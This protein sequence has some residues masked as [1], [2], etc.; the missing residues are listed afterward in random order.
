M[1]EK[2]SRRYFLNLSSLVV[3]ATIVEQVNT[4]L[5]AQLQGWKIGNKTNKLPLG[6][7]YLLGDDPKNTGILPPGTNKHLLA[8]GVRQPSRY[9]TKAFEVSSA[10]QKQVLGFENHIVV[11][12]NDRRMAA[13][14]NKNLLVIG[15]PV[16]TDNT[17]ALCGYLDVQSINDPNKTIPIIDPKSPLPFYFYIGNENGYGYWG[18]EYRS[19]RRWHENGKEDVFPLYGIYDKEKKIYL[20]QPQIGKKSLADML[21]IIRV[22]N[23]KNN[24]RTITIIG[25]LHGYSL[26]SFFLALESNMEIFSKSINPNGF[27]YFQALLPYSLDNNGVASFN[28]NGKGEWKTKI[29]EIEPKKFL[30][31][32]NSVKN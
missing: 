2:K 7:E 6:L 11:D 30:S 23:P 18:D 26:E 9:V 17:K 10:I 21:M 28:I 27:K 25:G 32:Q 19:I 13:N 29:K 24:S 22:P 8:K 5:F 3:A 15:G 12:Y 1:T 14:Q 20:P 4:N 16:A 31:Y